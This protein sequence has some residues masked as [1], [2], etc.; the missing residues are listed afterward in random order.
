MAGSYFSLNVRYKVLVFTQKSKGDLVAA[1]YLILYQKN[2]ELGIQKSGITTPLFHRRIPRKP[3]V[4]AERSS[5][6]SGPQC[7][8][9]Q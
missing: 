1:F 3:F 9:A 8:D 7:G 5:Q 4:G 6:Q 2:A